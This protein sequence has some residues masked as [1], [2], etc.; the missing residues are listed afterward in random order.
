MNRFR[1]IALPCLACIVAAGATNAAVDTENPARQYQ[2]TEPL[3]ERIDPSKITEGDVPPL[4]TSIIAPMPP[5]FRI[6]MEAESAP[7]DADTWIRTVASIDRG[8][9][10]LRSR[11][12]PGGFWMIQT[13]T[14]PTDEPE[15][16]TP[17]AAAVTAMGLQSF[18]QRGLDPDVDPTLSKAVIAIMGSRDQKEL[19]AN[20]LANYIQSAMVSGL[21]S[22]ED[23]RFR[24]AVTDGVQSLTRQQWNGEEGI[25]MRADWFGGAGY[26]NRGRPD[27]S[28]TQSMLQ[29]LHD[30]GMSPDEPAFQE[31]I[32]FL[33]RTQNLQSVNDA[34]WAGDDGGFVYTPANGGES[35]AS[36][37]AGEG[38]YGELVPA[39]TPRSLRSYGSMT[40]AGFKSLLYAGLDENDPRVKAAFE[41]IRR[42]WSF[43]ENPG[44]DQ[45]GLYYYWLAM[46]RALRAS[47]Q[48]VITDVDGTPHRWREEL[49]EA[50]IR[51]QR[52][53]GSWRNDEDRWLE[54]E[55][56]LATVYALL[57][58]EE[59][60]K[61]DPA[62]SPEQ[63]EP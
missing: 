62:A 47:R 8:L 1:H 41:W 9:D 18:A 53:D 19:L 5:T 34:T 35:M 48:T 3:D 17:V 51:R 52:L 10:F 54:G 32:V 29:A 36:Q 11:Q 21:A 45:Q 56:E 38:R 4:P 60:L 46:A 31:A 39:G 12:S 61:P 23:D 33:S 25:A 14:P 27:L 26:G 63:V 30:S 15:Q 58:L 44:L 22:L 37:L 40:Y 6:A 28:N 43:E 7:V 2:P 55:Q 59:L 16:V 50:I 20:P 13:E 57:A 24:E 42:H 49:A